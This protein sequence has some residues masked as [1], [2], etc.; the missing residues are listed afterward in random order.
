MLLF[1]MLNTAQDA[2]DSGESYPYNARK[3]WLSILA[4]QPM[5]DVMNIVP[6]IEYF[7]TAD[8]YLHWS[9]G[10]DGSSWTDRR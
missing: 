10:L 4:L 3:S 8:Q 5:S 6:A 1:S 7:S 2:L 9:G